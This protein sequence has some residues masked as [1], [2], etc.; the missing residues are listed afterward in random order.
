L[1]TIYIDCPCALLYNREMSSITDV[2]KQAGVS[3][4]TVSRTF[5][6]PHLISPGTRQRVRETALRLNYRP[7]RLRTQEDR[8]KSPLRLSAAIGFQFFAAEPSDMLLSNT[9]YAHV[10]AGALAEASTLGVHLLVHTTDR[11]A[12]SQEL[13]RMVEERAVAGLM[14]VGNADRDALRILSSRVPDIV[15]VDHRDDDGEYECVLSDGFGGTMAAASS[16]L[17]RGHRR[18]AFFG[19]EPGVASFRDR[20]RGYCCAHVEAGM[21]YDDALVIGGSE[22]ENVTRL[23]S[24]LASGERPTALV[25][26]NDHYASLAIA[27]C[28]K[29]G[30]RIPRDLSLIGFDDVAF[31]RRFDPPL[32]TVR[33]DKELMGR[34][35]MQRLFARLGH[36][37]EK[38]FAPPPPIRTIVP[39]NLVLR[40][41]CRSL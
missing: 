24:V 18:I 20:L 7:R 6:D 16:L 11:T 14:I 35:A 33:V 23:A 10:L 26:A 30:M 25:S 19:A 1:H 12:L 5:N 32:S 36:T 41:S 4:A 31:A 22:A 39:V 38:P 13:P 28:R 27:H 21:P 17:A 9:F 29:A 2:A 37:G 40:D 15:L 3:T 34:V 8:T